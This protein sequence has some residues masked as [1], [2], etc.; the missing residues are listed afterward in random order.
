MKETTSIHSPIALKNM[1][2]YKIIQTKELKTCLN[3]KNLLDD[4]RKDAISKK[5]PIIDEVLGRILEVICFI[6]KPRNVLEIGCGVGYSSYFIIKELKAGSYI[7][8]DL[9]KR[10]LELAEKFIKSIFP[11]T[12]CAFITGNAV[13][14]IPNLKIKFD[15]IFIDAAKY[16]YPFYIKKLMNEMNTGAIIIA[17][18]VFYKGKIFE[19][20]I[21]KHD[22]NSVK[23]IREYIKII[24]DANLFETNFLKIGD[25]VSISIFKGS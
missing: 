17:D 7:G 16:E 8:I 2:N 18:N 24:T 22:Y 19:E 25:G 4:V 15:M 5:I 10:R 12:K 1:N 13:K 21:S 23:G 3:K 14:I 9:N 6:K 11:G 20:N